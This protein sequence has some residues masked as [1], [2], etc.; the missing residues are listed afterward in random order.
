MSHP[1]APAANRLRTWVVLAL[2]LLTSGCG[3]PLPG[4]AMSSPTATS[5]PPT[6]AVQLRTGGADLAVA[7][8]FDA[9]VAMQ[10]PLGGATR[11][12]VARRLLAEHVQAQPVDARLGLWAFGHRHRLSERAASCAD[13]EQLAAL[14]PGQ[15]MRIVDRLAHVQAQGLAP[16]TAA[17]EASLLDLRGATAG[18]KHAV[19][20]AGGGD[21]CGRDPCAAVQAL[22]AGDAGLPV[23]VLALAVDPVAANALR[24]V[25]QATGG[26]FYPVQDESQM[27]QALAEVVTA[28]AATPTPPPEAPLASPTA[29]PTTDLTPAAPPPTTL[30]TA[31][32]LPDTPSPPPT[33]TTAAVRTARP[34][35][36]TP[37]P[38]VTP[39]ATA[40]A[41]PPAA[42]PLQPTATP[43]VETLQTVN[44]RAGPGLVYPVIGRLPAGARLTPLASYLNRAESRV[45]LL[46]CCLADGRTGWVAAELVTAPPA[47]LPTPATVPPSPTLSPTPRITATPTPAPTATP[48]KEEVPTPKVPTPD[49]KPPIPTPR[50]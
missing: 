30:P 40:P 49:I 23:H 28:M 42:S 32:A 44:V 1:A 34:A 31:A 41:S 35:L 29:G 13:V 16:L 21:T 33:P 50:P 17:L 26:Q 25:A 7:Y 10:A 24:C 6:T 15:G 47:T 19:L 20:I 11:L 5:S 45:W 48:V 12:E 27:A 39:S 22:T 46:V 8:I 37:S 2:L 3:T 36:P 4:R 14:M 38:T 43:Y 18:R 9:S